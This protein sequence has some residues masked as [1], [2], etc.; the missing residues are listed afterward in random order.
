MSPAVLRRLVQGSL[1]DMVSE[2]TPGLRRR[3]PSSRER[4]R[5]SLGCA[6][7]FTAPQLCSSK[8]K[9]AM[10]TMLLKNGAGCCSSTVVFTKTRGL[11]LAPGHVCR[12]WPSSRPTWRL[13]S[14]ECVN[15]L[16]G[17]ARLVFHVLGSLWSAQCSQRTASVQEHALVGH[18]IL[19]LCP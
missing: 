14:N 8:G 18:I 11:D 10:G 17:E 2:G 13:V 9:A 5:G 1:S 16:G 6:G 3:G 7:L 12:V 15:F 4:P 19:L